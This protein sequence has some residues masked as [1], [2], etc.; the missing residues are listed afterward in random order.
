MKEG[1]DFVMEEHKI[2]NIKLR[3]QNQSIKDTKTKIKEREKQL[4][5]LY[6]QKYPNR[7]KLIWFLI[8]LALLSNIGA[9]I[10]TNALI[11]KETPDVKMVEA[12]PVQC[13]VGGYECVE[14]K[15][16]GWAVIGAFYLHAI[17]YTYFIMYYVLAR[18]GI[19][20][21]KKYYM[22]LGLYLFITLL[23]FKDFVHDLGYYVG[24]M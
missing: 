15:W 16:V 8:A 23:L 9:T 22:V 24:F 18:K 3:N 1:Y 2:L 17:I 6:R 11:V 12:N 13:G 5:G 14:D 10:L 20:N 4:S 21:D 19:W 7:F